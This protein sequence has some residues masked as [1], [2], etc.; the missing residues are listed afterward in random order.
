LQDFKN[1]ITIL[2]RLRHPNVV[3]YIGAASKLPDVCIVTEWC[4]KASLSDLLYSEQPLDFSLLMHIAIDIA[5]GM[6][7]LHSLEPQIIHRDL[8]SGNV[9][10]DKNYTAKV[11]DFGLSFKKNNTEKES[12]KHGILGTPEWMAPEVMND[13]SYNHKVDVYSFGIVLCELFSRIKPYSDQFKISSF[14]DAVDHILDEGAIPTIPKWCGEQLEDL[15]RACIKR[16]SS[17]RPSFS[18]IVATLR[19]IY[20]GVPASEIFFQFEIPRIMEMILCKN[21]VFQKIACKELMDIQLRQ[22]TKF[23]CKRCRHSPEESQR[24]SALDE[25][26]LGLLIMEVA[27]IF[28][29][30]NE[31]LI[32][33]S[34]MAFYEIIT[35]LESRNLAQCRSILREHGGL[36][37]LL[38][39]LSS[40]SMDIRNSASKV[41]LHLTNELDAEEQ[42]KFFDLSYAGLS[43]LAALSGGY[44]G[45]EKL[46]AAVDDEKDQLIQRKLELEALILQKTQLSER[47]KVAQETMQSKFEIEAV[48]TLRR[49]TLF[50][51]LQFKSDDAQSQ[52]KAAAALNVTHI[53]EEDDIENSEIPIIE[54]LPLSFVDYYGDF[55]RTLH[56][57]ALI[58]DSSKERWELR[59]LFLYGDEIRVFVTHEGEPDDP[60][61]ILYI[62]REA[63]NPCKASTLSSHDKANC[64]Q[65]SVS[66]ETF[67]FSFRTNFDSLLWAHWIEPSA[68][69]APSENKKVQKSSK[70]DGGLENKLSA[71]SQTSVTEALQVAKGMPAIAS[72]PEAFQEYFEGLDISNHGYL[73]VNDVISGHWVHRY[74]I[75][76]NGVL[77]VFGTHEDSP[78][79]CQ[80]I[81][82]T[83][84]SMASPQFEIGIQKDGSSEWAQFSFVMKDDAGV[85][86]ICA[87]S[88]AER[89]QWVQGIS[90]S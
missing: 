13:Q 46:K 28:S 31:D 75:L 11:C 64:I 37:R 50:G 61:N 23:E 82:Y 66:G 47:L 45:V 62:D 27:N 69:E 52:K 88:L 12:G 60:L 89:D 74:C 71:M 85:Y 77:R 21:E 9:L 58:W 19:A 90:P 7:Y 51:K 44:R 48:S 83:S 35:D 17:Q 8:K 14:I 24:V 65:V 4:D 56:A 43:A 73:A 49:G 33:H 39:F 2:S 80:M 87:K 20:D 59:Y 6:N 79:D 34:L 5:Q 76:V 54:D 72:L 15:I 53:I 86:C 57:Y 78:D 38:V 18:T 25:E 3:L 40:Q 26:T 70:A 10:L 16:E 41:M 68:N 1:E 30:K 22:K 42:L 84:G 32:L 36:K 63:K 67:T 81:V 29:S 55:K